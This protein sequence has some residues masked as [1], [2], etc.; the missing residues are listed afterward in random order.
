MTEL[1]DGNDLTWQR[2]ANTDRELAEKLRG[3]SGDFTLKLLGKDEKPAATPAHPLTG[4]AAGLA[5]GAIEVEGSVGDYLCLLAAG[6]SV[7]VRGHAGDGCG[8]SMVAGRILVG[9]NVGKYAAAYASGGF[10]AVLGTAG[11]RCG[12]G[13]AGADVLIRSKVGDEAGCCMCD[14]A[15]VLGN[16][17]GERLGVGMTG[18]VIFVRGDVKSKADHMRSIRLK[19]AD[20]MRLSLLLARAGIKAGGVEFKAYRPRVASHE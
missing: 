13:L 10:I 16:G 1:S 3:L 2:S 15:L 20:S 6:V 17:A 14:G 11:D 19:D 4:L 9:G 8:H 18:G 12:Q 5:A 7:D